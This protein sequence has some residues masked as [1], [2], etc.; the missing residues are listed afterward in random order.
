VREEASTIIMCA[1]PARVYT[2]TDSP[3]PSRVVVLAVVV[4]SR[5]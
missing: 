1:D 2:V 3:H 5:V 4:V